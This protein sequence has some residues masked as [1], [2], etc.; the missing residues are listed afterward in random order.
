MEL[1]ELK[2]AYPRW[3]FWRGLSGVL[4]ASRLMTSPP[5]V[6]RS[7]TVEGLRDQ[8]EAETRYREDYYG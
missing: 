6:K 7:P 8:V 3:H 2:H 1:N 4:Y 5:V